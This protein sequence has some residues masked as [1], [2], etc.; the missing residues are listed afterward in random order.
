M[1]PE[2]PARIIV[3]RT[4]VASFV[5]KSGQAT[6]LEFITSQETRFSN[7]VGVC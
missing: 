7:R 2:A 3:D 1:T 5:P 6:L 4:R